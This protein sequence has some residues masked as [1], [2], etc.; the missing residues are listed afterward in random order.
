MSSPNHAHPR[1]LQADRAIMWSRWWPVWG[2]GK[3]LIGRS[4]VVGVGQDELGGGVCGRATSW[5]AQGA[6]EALQARGQHHVV[7]GLAQLS[8]AAGW[9]SQGLYRIDAQ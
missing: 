7:R 1:A 2:Q 4:A 8:R 5:P 9:R 6:A 3:Q